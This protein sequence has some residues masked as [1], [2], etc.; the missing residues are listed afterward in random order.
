VP[1]TAGRSHGRQG[2]H[3][4]TRGAVGEHM[5][6]IMTALITGLVV[7]T[8][9]LVMTK[10]GQDI[11]AAT[12][13]FMLFY[14]GVFA[15]IGLTASVGVGLVATDRIIMTPGRRVMAQAVH[16]AVSFGALA[17][18]II[19]IV[20]EILAQ[21]V[22]VIDAFIPFLSP[23]RTFYIGLGTIA[24]DLLLLIVV[25]SIVRKRFTAHGKAWRWRAIHYSSYLA[26]VFGVLHGLLGGRAAKPY[27][28]WSYG[29]AIALTALAVAARFLAI[30]LRSKDKVSAA[31]GVDRAVGGL[32]YSGTSPLR[33]AALSMAQSQLGA[34]IQMLP[35]AAGAQGSGLG[36]P[37]SGLGLPGVPPRAALPPAPGW[38]ALPPAPGWSTSSGSLSPFP[39]GAGYAED[40]SLM[41][42]GAPVY[43]A[44]MTAGTRGYPFPGAPG[45]Q[46]RY[47]P[48]YDGPPRFEG[49]SRK[50]LS[51]DDLSSYPY[52]APS[53]RPGWGE[54]NTG[55]LPLSPPPR[56]GSGPMP[57]TDTGPMPRLGTGPMPRTDTG[58]MPRL[59]TGPTPRADSGPMPRLGTGPI[60][61]ADPGPRPRADSGPMP[62]LG[63][64]PMPRTDTGP[65][66]RVDA[67]PA[68]RPGAGPM[69]RADSG[70]MPRL[71][72]GPMP[73][74]DTGPMPR[75][76][77]GPMPIPGAGSMSR[78]DS[79]PM[80]RSGPGPVPRPDTGP[81]RRPGPGPASRADTGPMPRIDTGPRPRGGS[82][83]RPRIES[84]PAS[85][86][87]SGP[88]PRLGTGPVPRADSGPMPRLGT[89]P[90]HGADYG[91]APRNGTGPNPRATGSPPSGD[92]GP[93]PGTGPVPSPDPYHGP[94][95]GPAPATATRRSRRTH[96]AD[97]RYRDTSGRPGG[98][99]WR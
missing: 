47:E 37:G 71:G 63:T 5:P 48:E 40:P 77:S 9:T 44:P 28:D 12:Q 46:P 87:D 75:L 69:P 60:P 93:R 32:G 21:R 50:H 84:G 19:H 82:D 70:P 35:A 15:L 78:A 41:P 53:R 67:G 89:G 52:A 30:S 2:V 29:F 91:S 64:G 62:R 95:T 10:P 96:A 54:G 74:T 73:R 65:M 24:S 23:Y 31:P 42:L 72:T 36:L 68:P 43:E 8:F 61:R 16:R 18:L 90:R 81:V 94:P 56:H 25:T 3:S 79:G 76:G 20:T 6:K 39:A 14:A 17:F 38:A 88:M 11:D 49:A 45:R 22:H 86:T 1:S 92:G 27:V 99:E 55:P 58:A 26:F 97:P 80:P 83:P 57:R 66:P 51:Q 34:T 4:G 85:R 13:R 33:S 7:I 98:D 59:A